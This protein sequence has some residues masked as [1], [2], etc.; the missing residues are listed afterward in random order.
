MVDR[1]D[2]PKHPIRVVAR[3]TGLST[4]AI[5]A[6]ERRYAAVEPTRSEGG[7]RL[8][9]DKNLRRLEALR[10]LTERGR[11]ISSVAGLD[12][13]ALAG[14]LLEDRM[15]DGRRLTAPTRHDAEGRIEVAYSCIL[16]F[17]GSGLERVLWQSFSQMGCDA[18]LE[19]VVGPLLQRVGM[20]WHDGHLTP[21]QEHFGSEVIDRVLERCAARASDDGGPTMVVTTLPDEPHGLGARIVATAASVRGWRVAYLGTDLPVEEIV[22]AA[23]A[24]EARAVAVSIV[25]TARMG[26]TQAALRALRS[27]L[28]PS[29]ALLVGGRAV[30]AL[31]RSGMQ[32]GLWVYEEL[33]SLPHAAHDFA[34]SSES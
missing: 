17:D 26:E 29:R 9:S 20:G 27:R 19:G 8:Y 31:D 34:E 7:Q 25:S 30:G 24:V 32:P 4:A 18:F 21:A 23:D 12:D 11:S 22:A 33:R 14:L 1:D 6:W 13:E 16:D 2:M 5:R 15:S 28:S 3:R 10:E